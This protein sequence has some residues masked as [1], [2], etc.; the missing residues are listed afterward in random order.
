MTIQ[1]FPGSPSV[2]RTVSREEG[3][4]LQVTLQGWVALWSLLKILHFNRQI[5]DFLVGK[6]SRTHCSVV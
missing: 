1:V 2:A 6:K 3:G 5:K 4:R